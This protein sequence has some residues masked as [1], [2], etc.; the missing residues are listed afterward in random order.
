MRVRNPR[1]LYSNITD[2]DK[3]N[4]FTKHG[5]DT[6]NK[7]KRF[8]HIKWY[9]GYLIAFFSIAMR[10]F[11][12]TYCLFMLSSR[13]GADLFIARPLVFA[14]VSMMFRRPMINPL[15]TIFACSCPQHWEKAN[16]SGF[17]FYSNADSVKCWLSLYCPIVILIQISAAIAA[18][19]TKDYNSQL[20]GDEFINNAA[21]GT[22]QLRLRVDTTIGRGSCW[23]IPNGN[24]TQVAEIS[25]HNSLINDS[26]DCLSKIQGGWWF[27]EDMAS[28]LFLIA[29]YV[30]VWKWLRWDDL[31]D[32][33]P[34]DSERRY[35]MKI[36]AFSAAVGIF[37]LMNAMAFPTANTGWHVSIYL[38]VLQKLRGD[39]II[40]SNTYLEPLIRAAGSFTG[41]ILAILYEYLIIWVDSNEESSFTERMHILLYTFSYEWHLP[42]K[43]KKP[44]E[45]N[46]TAIDNNDTQSNAS[47]VN[48]EN[49]SLPEKQLPNLEQSDLINPHRASSAALLFDISPSDLKSAHSSSQSRN[50][51][52]PSGASGARP[53]PSEARWRIPL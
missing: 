40:T 46:S 38:Y 10:E 17:P 22:G 19:Y 4:I 18:A 24:I 27:A 2:P 28:M 35:W 36:A 20:F 52:R 1:F 16:I 50:P 39:L 48:K 26:H 43:P 8:A 15:V 47:N 21:W 34:A 31:K 45:T 49:D 3:D 33:N 30:H 7:V 23:N 14:Y 37:N 12:A 42:I 53:P 13:L 32:L 51:R 9:E 6:K 29:S 44:T 25:S 11:M 41:C 5:D